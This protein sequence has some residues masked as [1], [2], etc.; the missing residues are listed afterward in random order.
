MNYIFCIYFWEKRARTASNMFCHSNVKL[1][2]GLYE[3][4]DAGE[5]GPLHTDKAQT[6]VD[7]HARDEHT[8]SAGLWHD[9]H[10]GFDR[11]LFYFKYVTSATDRFLLWVDNDQWQRLVHLCGLDYSTT[12]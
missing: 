1:K 3:R 6:P 9:L 8:I 4:Q 12:G 2:R 5:I 7:A 10:L 11:V